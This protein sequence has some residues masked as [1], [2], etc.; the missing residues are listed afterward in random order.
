MKA[1]HIEHFR[2]LSNFR[3]ITDFNNN[4]EQWMTD[5]KKEFTKAELVA[6][7]RLIRFCAKV[8]GICNAKIGTIV[9]ATHEKDNVGISR[10]TFKRMLTKA[11]DLGLLIIHETARKNGSQS[12]NVYVFS[13]F[14]LTHVEPPKDEK[15]NHPQTDNFLETSKKNNNIRKEKVNDTVQAVTKLDASFVSKG[16]PER[17]VN[18]VKSFYD[19]A[20]TIEEYWKITSISARTQKVY[21]DNEIVLETALEAFRTVIK[22]VKFSTVTNPYGFFYGVCM[23]KF[24]TVYLHELFNNWWQE[25][26]T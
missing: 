17:F 10:S 15:L 7:K 25:S 21:G 22:K 1:G 3:D 13:R 8:A 19:D 4:I 5:I 23:K 26:V 9:S 12:S 16:V 20:K 14:E 2:H 11:K 18:L 6:L 24:R